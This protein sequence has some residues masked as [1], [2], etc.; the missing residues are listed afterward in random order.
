MCEKH[1][2]FEWKNINIDVPASDKWELPCDTYRHW[3]IVYTCKEWVGVYSQVWS[4]KSLS[5][6]IIAMMGSTFWQI[7]CEP[8]RHSHP[9]LIGVNLPKGDRWSTHKIDVF[10]RASP[11]SHSKHWFVDLSKFD[12]WSDQWIHVFVRISYLTCCLALSSVVSRCLLQ[13]SVV[14]CCKEL[15]TAV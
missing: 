11:T 10:Q 1:Q 14:Y 9:Q 6:V 5:L 12:V 2:R 15:Y 7:W 13:S 3:Y 8:R 4:Y